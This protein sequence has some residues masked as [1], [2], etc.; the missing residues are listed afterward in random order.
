MDQDKISGGIS[1]P[2]SDPIV[3]TNH[4][5]RAHDHHHASAEAASRGHKADAPHLATDVVCGMTVDMDATA[6]RA[7]YRGQTYYFCCGG[8]RAKF[9][10]D[11]QHY[12]GG[13]AK[14]PEP[15]QE[16]AI[17][18]CPMHPEI[19]QVGP[20]SCPICGMALEPLVVTTETAPNRELIDMTRRF[21]IGLAL[22]LPVVAFEMGGHFAH[23]R[24]WLDQSVSNWLQLAFATPVVLWAGWSFF[25]RGWQSILTRNLNMFTLIA[26]GTGVAWTYSVIATLAPALFPPAFRAAD[27]A[28][29]VYFE[30]AAGITVL[31]LLGQVLELSARERTSGA[32]RALLDLAPKPARRIGDDGSEAEVPLELVAVGDRLRVRPGEKDSGGWRADRG[33]LLGR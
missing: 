28:V 20:G 4:G 29:A 10:A 18:T 11:P 15:A 5:H 21:W 13:A 26:I 6:H 30:A 3:E 2:S 27:G 33:S 31:V 9:V 32:I 1:P 16:G 14:V 22:T 8:C 24:M 19:H 7:D 12:L 23:G 17:Y 25:V